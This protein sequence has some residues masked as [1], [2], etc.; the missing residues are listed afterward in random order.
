[1]KKRRIGLL[2]LALLVLAAAVYHFSRP[3]SRG[4]LYRISGGKNEML[5]LGSIHMGS[6]AMYPMRK[7]IIQGIQQADALVF[8]C[9][10]QSEEAAAVTAQMMRCPQGETLSGFISPETRSLL[11]QTAEQT[12]LDDSMLE[13]LRPWAV[14]SLLSVETASAQMT[15][16]S[17]LAASLGV[18]TMVRKN[19]AGQPELYLETA[20][21]QLGLMDAFSPELQEYLLWS[22]CESI[23]NPQ[24]E[25]DVSS[26][27]AW[28]AEGRADA[29]ADS[30]L[31][32]FA[33]E[34][35]P[36][37]AQEYHSQLISAR[38][39]RM[40]QRLQELLESGENQRYFVTIGL[41]HLVLP[42]DSVLSALEEMGYRVEQ[43]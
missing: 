26:W 4:I 8:E 30:Y 27:P 41:M 43:I 22:A 40:A 29:F 39:E 1:M 14:T 12:G 11:S 38:N 34:K 7:E 32:S 20:E 19:A 10:T 42:D 2:L 37:L 21:E 28:W 9:D 31:K 25:Q 13:T 24:E 36:A 35:E 17:R 3:V 15:G 18:E 5:V 6:P 16:S 23:L 33:A